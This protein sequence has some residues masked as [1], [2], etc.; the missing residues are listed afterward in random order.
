MTD[1]CTTEIKAILYKLVNFMHFELSQE[2]GLETGII[3]KYGFRNVISNHL[4]VPWFEM[5]HERSINPVNACTRQ[6]LINWLI[7]IVP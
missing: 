7:Y 5:K 3:R 6:P 4:L 1:W 2:S